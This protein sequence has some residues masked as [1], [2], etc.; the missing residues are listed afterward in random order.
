MKTGSINLPLH[1]GKA[2]YW[3]FSR[4]VRLSREILSVIVSEFGPKEVLLRL[5]DPLWF[6]ALGCILGFDWHSSG[7]TTTVCGSIK[8]A[9]KG[10]ENDFGF[11]A[12]GGKGATSRKTPLEIEE[13]SFKT[14]KDFSELVYASKIS[15][16]VDNNALQDGYQLYHHCFFFTTD[17]GNWAVVQQGMNELNNFARRYHWHCSNVKDFVCEP[18]TAICSNGKTDVINLIDK[19]S[20]SA[21][22]I[23]TELSNEKPEKIIKDIRSLFEENYSHHSFPKRHQIILND[24]ETTRMKKIFLSTYESKPK[25]F[26]KLLALKGVGP[27]TIRSLALISELIYKTP[28]SI[29]DPARFS[30]AHGGKDGIPY[31]VD[32]EN[33]E[34]SIEILNIALK[35]SKIN[36]T[37]KIKAL[38][39]LANFY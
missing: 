35:N 14:G 39:R 20:E 28:Y 30:F 27:K 16:K 3:L 18:H 11:F 8:E 34:K 10:S 36:K 4:M 13:A 1:G 37:D 12:A 22:H 9:I 24:I 15:A 6:Q 2:P 33:Y 17:G 23:I 7:V 38:K 5:S 29:K 26:E 25:D 21:R 31:P 19:T 32:R